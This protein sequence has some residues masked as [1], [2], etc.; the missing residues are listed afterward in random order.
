M[1]GAFAECDR[2]LVGGLRE[3][4][5]SDVEIAGGGKFFVRDGKHCQLLLRV[6]QVA[7]VVEESLRRLDPRDMGVAENREAVG[8][9]A[10]HVI[11]RVGKRGRRLQRQ[12][13]NQIDVD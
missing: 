10:E 1:Q 8:F 3:V 13:E 2:E 9:E 7:P 4:I 11:D 12:T 6:G 5:E